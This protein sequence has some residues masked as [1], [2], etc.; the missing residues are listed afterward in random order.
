MNNNSQEFES[1]K[2]D[3]MEKLK[4]NT[5]NNLKNFLK[6]LGLPS[7]GTDVGRIDRAASFLAT[8]EGKKRAMKILPS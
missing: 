4:G 7:A 5:S 3:F 6:K 2:Q 8:E 1:K